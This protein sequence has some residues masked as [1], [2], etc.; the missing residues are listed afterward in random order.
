ME[1]KNKI[2][3]PELATYFH[4]EDAA[5]EFLE[6][7]RWPDGVVCPH[8][9]SINEHYRIVPKE[10][11]KTRKGLWKCKDCRKQFSVTVGTV[12][13]GSHIPIHIWLYAIH[14][15][16]SA[17]KGVSAHQLHRKLGITYKSAWFM[18][19][20]IRFIMEGDTPL[21]EKM[22]GI[23]ECDETYVGG[24]G[25]GL[26]KK[27]CGRGTLKTPVFALV[28]RDGRVKSQVVERVTGKN[29]KGIIKKNVE[30]ASTIMTDDFKSYKGLNKIFYAHKVVEHGKKIYSKPGGIHTNTIEGYF[31]ILKRGIVGVYQHVGKQHLDRYLAEFDFRYNARK[32]TDGERAVLALKGIEGKRLMYRDSS[33]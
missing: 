16:S 15:M 11:S 32:V 20:R 19:H 13:E 10:G 4:N 25:K 6:K 21:A 30:T 31:S 3:L 8:C 22:K 2:T 14:E 27:F 7:L 18:A 12:F 23:V 26:G 28:E 17:K 24:K 29:L 9:G 33:L 5:R 1:T